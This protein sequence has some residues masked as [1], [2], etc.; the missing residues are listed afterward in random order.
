[1][2]DTTIYATPAASN[3][4]V[5]PPAIM[6]G[7]TAIVGVAETEAPWSGMPEHAYHYRADDSLQFVE[8]VPTRPMYV[9]WGSHHVQNWP[10]LG[11][12]L[13]VVIIAGVVVVVAIVRPIAYR[14]ASRF[15]CIEPPI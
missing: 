14:V 2:S 3:A 8:E 6:T 12:E 5:P 15:H 11:L 4:V 10:A 7:G 1:M 9:T 13:L